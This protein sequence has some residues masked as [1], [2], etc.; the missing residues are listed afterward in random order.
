[1]I[2]N[3]SGFTLI[4]LVMVIVILGILA[5][6]ALPK[7]ADLS[8]EAGKS[9]ANG[10]LGGARAA[11]SINFASVAVG[12]TGYTALADAGDMADAMGT[13]PNECVSGTAA[14]DLVTAN[15]TLTW[16]CTFDAT[17]YTYTMT[18]EAA[19]SPSEVS[20]PLCD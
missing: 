9:A 2:R 4:E 5:A 11:A 13:V 16:D 8:D 10:V 12:A 3:Q 14:D 7:F 17:A 15:A 18:A 20:C 19:D 1:M 6:S